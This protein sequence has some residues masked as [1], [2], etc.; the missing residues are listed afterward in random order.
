MVTQPTPGTVA[1]APWPRTSAATPS[2]RTS[3]HGGD[4][5]SVAIVGAGPGGLATAMLLAHA[6]WQVTVYEAH[7]TVGGRTRQLE[8]GPYRFDCGPTFFMMPWVLEEIFEATGRKLADYAE[9]RRLDPMYRLLIGQPTGDPVVIDTTQDIARM[10][11]QLSAIEP[12]DGPAFERFIRDNRRKLE[13]MTPLLRRP[14]RGL[15]DLFS[16]DA[17]RAGPALRPWQSLYDHLKG[18][19][20]HEGVRLAMSFQSKYLGMSPFECPELFSILPFIEYEYGIWHPIGGCSALMRAMADA[21]TEMGVEVRCGEP[22]EQ[23]L[24]QGKR[25]SGV[26]VAGRHERHDHVVVNADAAWA[27]KNLVPS[28]VRPRALKDDALDAKRFSC[29]TFMMYLGV[30]GTVDLPHHTIY[31]SRSYVSNLQDISRNGTLSDDPSTYVCNPSR[32]DPTLA[33]PGHSSLYVLVPTPNNK[34][35]E[36]NVDWHWARGELRERTLRQLEDV[37][38][39]RDIRSRIRAEHLVTPADWQS[40]RI[41]HGATFNMAHNLGQML[42]RRPHHRVQGM[43]NLWLVGGGTHPGSGLPVIFLSAEITSRLMCAEEGLP[44]PVGAGATGLRAAT[45]A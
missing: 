30:E 17:M 1:T 9:L 36:C 38:G 43:D 7:A 12:S 35:G 22:V 28:E 13:V 14:I 42:H 37:F 41:A 15:R 4:G 45:T 2:G 19:F 39:I 20:R 3:P 18:Y 16:L 11:R 21:C 27:L 34:K 44:D 26:R 10:S 40:E 32:I 6:G 24:F 31:T 5:R 23:V 33:P 25:A 8:V 29:S